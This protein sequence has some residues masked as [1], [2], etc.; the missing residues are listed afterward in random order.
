EPL[1]QTMQLPDEKGQE[2]VLTRPFVPRGK[3]NQLT[4]FM[5]ARADPAH[6]G[7]LIV[8]NTPDNSTAPSPSRA[9]TLIESEQA[10]SQQFTLLG[11]QGSDVLRG[12]VQL[13]PVGDSILYVRPIWVEGK[14]ASPY[15]R[16]RFVAMA[17]GER[18]VLAHNVDDAVNAL[19]GGGS[20][21]PPPE[22][23][24][25]GTTTPP[26]PNQAGS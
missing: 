14:G 16:F 5:A 24:N 1:Y 11:Q 25:G 4:A 26:G 13:I 3:E 7:K 2:F 21:T 18:A 22:G 12:Q 19:F 17:Y 23:E 6:Y 15:P 8:Y 9:G 10:I 20:T